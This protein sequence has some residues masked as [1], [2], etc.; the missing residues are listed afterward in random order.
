MADFDDDLRSLTDKAYPSLQEE[1]CLLTQLPQ[2]QIA[3]SVHQ[4]QPTTLDDAVAA[5]LE[6]E[7]Y[8][9][10]HTTSGINSTLSS[11]DGTHFCQCGLC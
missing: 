1:A 6:Q 3:F 4:K 8:I 2:L 7:S 9:P 10:P 11:D 5:T